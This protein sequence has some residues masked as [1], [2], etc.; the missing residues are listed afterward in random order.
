MPSTISP[1]L[2]VFISYTGN[3]L[4]LYAKKV[5]E[6]IT[7]LHWVP[8]YHDNWAAS[9]QLTVPACLDMVSQCNLVVVL[10]AH[11]YGWVPSEEEG[12]DGI[13]S[14]TRLEVEHARRL[15]IP[16]LPY[17]IKDNYPWQ[18][19]HN[20]ALENPEVAIHL[21]GFKDDLKKT[22][23]GFFGDPEELAADVSIALQKA[24]EPILN[25]LA[26]K[27][28]RQKK[29]I[30][31]ASLLIICVVFMY[32]L[33]SPT[34][35]KSIV[36]MDS[37]YRVF[38][39]DN[40]NREI[41]NSKELNNLLL[42]LPVVM[43]SVTTTS[44]W[45]EKGCVQLRKKKIDLIVIHQSAFCE[46]TSPNANCHESEKELYSLFDC[47][48]D[49]D[50]KFLVYT[51]YTHGSSVIAAAKEKYPKLSKQIFYFPMTRNQA[52]KDTTFTFSN[53]A[54]RWEFKQKV[55][56]LLGIRSK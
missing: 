3:D 44:N 53:Q 39:Y 27:R 55:C 49:T 50:V 25:E 40:R 31:I 7:S 15:N 13:K 19:E 1:A 4:S 51:R 38:K 47:M 36:L 22:I 11:R 41:L 42:D 9:G 52:G 30:T 32:W 56:E 5:A 35:D 28:E 21:K 2:R 10:V 26:Q 46:E 24:G 34:P 43:E 8:V 12:G 54:I 37:Q 33:Y 20:E 45:V 6:V 48:Q 23:I 29:W 16:V 14:I 18:D 17:L